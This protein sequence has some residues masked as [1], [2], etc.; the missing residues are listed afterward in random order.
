MPGLFGGFGFGGNPRPRSAA[1]SSPSTLL[2]G[3]ER[4]Y[5]LDGDGIDTVGGINGVISGPSPAYEAGHISPEALYLG[6]STSNKFVANAYG[7][8]DFSASWWMYP[9]S[10]GFATFSG[11]IGNM[12]ADTNIAD[13]FVMGDGV[14]TSKLYT[15]ADVKTFTCDTLAWNHVVITRSASTGRLYFNGTQVGGTFSFTPQ[16]IATSSFY[17]ASRPDARDTDIR[18]QEVGLWNR[19]LTDAEVI[20][21]YAGGVGVTYP[22]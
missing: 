6:A 9:R 8:A 10:G 14:L 2:D 19:Q 13:W 16:S 5:S 15:G 20:E 21:L 12:K 18:A 17:I 11:V 1:G 7:G 3:L 22:F 4:Y